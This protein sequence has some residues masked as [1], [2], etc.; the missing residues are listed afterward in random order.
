MTT[1]K[2]PDADERTATYIVGLL[3]W[4]PGAEFTQKCIARALRRARKQEASWWNDQVSRFIVNDDPGKQ[5]ILEEMVD[6]LRR[7]P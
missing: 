4:W 2:K 5:R 1:R 6:R 3:R 7:K